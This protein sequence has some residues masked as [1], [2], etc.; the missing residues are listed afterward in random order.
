M[1]HDSQIAVLENQVAEIHKTIEGLP[2]LEGRLRLTEKAVEEMWECQKEILKNTQSIMLTQA[3]V[4]G[5]IAL[6]KKSIQVQEDQLRLT[7]DTLNSKADKG[8]LENLLTELAKKADKD[9]MNRKIALLW[10]VFL[11]LPGAC[12]AIAGLLW[13]F[14]GK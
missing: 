12:A 11:W 5:E 6:I 14:L 9:E 2:K 3:Q 13:H 7:R 4:S 1:D 8:V 10:T